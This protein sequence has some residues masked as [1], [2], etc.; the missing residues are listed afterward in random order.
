[1]NNE[2]EITKTIWAY[3]VQNGQET[4]GEWSYYGSDWEAKNPRDSYEKIQKDH[5]K[6]LEKVKTVGVDW[7]KTKNP[8]SNTKSGFAG[9]FCDADRVETLLGTLVLNDGSEYMIGVSNAATRFGDYCRAIAQIAHDNKR[10]NEIFG[11]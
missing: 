4:N 6:L 5:K 7:G 1:M 9:T 2:L 10:R 8:E 11:E 3:M